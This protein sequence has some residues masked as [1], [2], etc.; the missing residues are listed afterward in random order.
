MK[1]IRYPRTCW[2][3][4]CLGLLLAAGSVAE[5]G[6]RGVPPSEGIVNFGKVNDDL[7]RGAQPDAAGISNLKRLGVKTIVNLRKA[8]DVWKP[9]ES[10]AST[11]GIIYTNVPMSGLGRP[12]PKQVALALEMI[13][14]LPSPVFVHCEH[15][16]ERT[17]AII[18]A[19]RIQH[20]HWSNESA[21]EEAKRYGISK[22]AR[23]MRKFILEFGKASA[24]Q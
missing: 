17:G 9:E 18:A 6:N 1:A 24:K 3:T 15:G 16:C 21:M 10:A 20:D 8:N 19:Y 14:S 11:N 4:L 5:A 7:Y 2:M 12:S 22:L 13:E 23:G